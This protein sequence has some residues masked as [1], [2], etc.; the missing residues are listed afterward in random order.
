MPKE[1][2]TYLYEIGSGE[3]SKV[4]VASKKGKKS[5]ENYIIKKISFFS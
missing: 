3:L 1:D 2:Y 5:I 4:F